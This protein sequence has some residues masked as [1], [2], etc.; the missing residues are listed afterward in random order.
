MVYRLLR[1]A[2][3]VLVGLSVFAGG[4]NYAPLL[5]NWTLMRQPDVSFVWLITVDAF[6]FVICPL[7]GA[8]LGY[9]VSKWLLNWG[10]SVSKRIEIVLAR[11]P[12]QEL[13]AGA[14]GLLFGLIIANLIG[15]AFRDIPIIGSYVGI[16]LSAIL[17]LIGIRVGVQKG[18][19]FYRNYK[20]NW[21]DQRRKLEDLYAATI[22]AKTGSVPSTTSSV[23]SGGAVVPVPPRDMAL[24]KAGANGQL[25]GLSTA[26]LLDTSVIIDGRISDIYKTGFL[27]GPLVVPVFVLEELQRISDSADQL[28]RD[29]GRRGLDILHAMQE[30]KKLP[31]RII[32]DDYEDITEVDSKL[33]RLALERGWKLITNDFNLNKVAVLQGIPV[34]NLNE[35]ANA[36]KPV[37]VPGEQVTVHVVKEGKENNQGVAYLPDGTMIVIENGAKSIGKTIVAEVTSVLQ[38]NAGLLIFARIGGMAS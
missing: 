15:W 27:E 20:G 25:Q 23:A 5:R 37:M 12:E 33:M 32:N 35:L 14:V 8:G 7:I 38:T 22:N 6:C 28:K 13:T 17:G 18:P 9:W 11:R 4:E 36:V 30:D 19:E 26:K 16:A 21:D 1:Y 31:I 2:I 29:K 34:L 10:M 3:A 24:Y